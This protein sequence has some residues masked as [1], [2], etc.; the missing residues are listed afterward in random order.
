MHLTDEEIKFIRIIAKLV[1][2]NV[3]FI[4]RTDFIKQFNYTDK[5][6]EVLMKKMEDFGVIED[7]SHTL[8]SNGGYAVSFKPSTLSVEIMR[9][10][11]H[12]IA[13]AEGPDIV[14]QLIKRFRSNPKTAWLILFFL[15]LSLAIPMITSL[16]DLI[17]RIVEFFSKK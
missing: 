13:T 11:D 10:I 7:V 16:L 4:T 12:Q 5:E 15:F 8:D 9:E 14:D 1:E 17:S 3:R 2:E 6:Y